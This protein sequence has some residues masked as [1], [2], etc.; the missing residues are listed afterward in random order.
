MDCLET[1]TQLLYLF[2]VSF[3]FFLCGSLKS[4]AGLRVCVTGDRAFPQAS[5]A[6]V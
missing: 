3:P 4:A 1:L 2:Y 5:L 6:G